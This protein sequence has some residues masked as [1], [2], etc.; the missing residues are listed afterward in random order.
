MKK[1]IKLMESVPPV[2]ASNT[3]Q[4]MRIKRDATVMVNPGSGGGTG[5]F[6]DYIPS[7]AQVDIKGVAVELPDGEFSLPER[8]YQDPYQSGNEWFHAT[9]EPATVGRMNDKPEFRPGDMVQIEDVYGSVIGPGVGVFIAYST[10][11]KECIVSFDDKEM[12]VPTANVGAMLEQDAK[13]NFDEMDNDGNLSPMSL[14]SQNVKVEQEPAMDHRDEFSKWLGTVEEALNGGGI[15]VN[16]LPQSSGL[17]GC[18]EWDCQTCF[19]DQAGGEQPGMM[20]GPDMHGHEEACPMCGALCA[21]GHDQGPDVGGIGIVQ[22]PMDGMDMGG[23]EE[24]MEEVPMIDNEGVDGLVDEEDMDFEQPVER[25]KDGK[26]VKLGNI[27]QKFVPTGGNAAGE[28]SPLTYGEDNLSEIVGDDMDR[29]SDTPKFDD[30][31]GMPSWEEHDQ[32]MSFGNPSDADIEQMEE[33]ASQIMYIQQMGLSKSDRPYTEAD[34]ASMNPAQM[35]QC[36][37]EVVGNSPT[38]MG[39]DVM[40]EGIDNDVQVWLNR[41]KEYDALVEEKKEVPAF[42]KKGKSDDKKANDERNDKVGADVF[43]SNRDGKKDK[44]DEKDEGK[45]NNGKTTGFKAVAKKA[46]AEY[47]SKEAGEKV[48]GAVHAKMAKAGKLEESE[49]DPEVLSWMKRF[50]KLGKMS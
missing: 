29:S 48:A 47:G 38:A 34:F 42:L 30:E 26:G 11:G 33:M 43:K 12:L 4:S 2:L 20:G 16:M 3:D 15:D 50:D 21:G 44:I 19:P 25:G 14:A 40:A 39:T 9:Q 17:C 41:F 6:M 23:M 7:G 27:V 32:A 13:N 36:Y 31:S 45:H 28:D 24:P 8:D 10:T 49:V 35:K 1:W 22:A 46:A 5:R 37:Q 18:Q